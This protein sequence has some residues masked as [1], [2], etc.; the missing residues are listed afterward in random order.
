MPLVAVVGRPNVGKSTFFNRLTESRDSIVDDQPG[1][2]RDRVYGR[3]EW[4]GRGFSIVDTGGLVPDSEDRFEAAI[5]EQAAIAIDEADLILFLVDVTTGIT[6]LDQ[7]IALLLRRSEKPVLVVA[8]KADN[9]ERRWQ[10]ADFWQL[11]VGD[12]H[13]VSSINGIGTGDLLD[14]IVDAL[15]PA[16]PPADDTRLRVA[17]IGRPN[18]GKSSL[19]NAW[20]G[21]ERSIV[22]EIS[23]TTRDSIDSVLKYHGREIV[24]VDTAGL[25]KRARIQENVEFYALL[26]TERAIDECDVAV[27]L[28]DATGGLESQDIRVLKKAEELR[29]GL[30]IGINKWDVIEKDTHTVR[31]YEQVVR[32][33]LATLDY[34]P[35]VT[36]SALSKQRIQKLLETTLAV[37]DNLHR[38]VTTS[39]L[40]DTILPAIEA[41]KPP[42]Y[43]GALVKIKYATQTRTAPPV[44]VFF[45]NHPSGLKEPYRRYLERRLRD[46]FDFTGVPLTVSFR[47]K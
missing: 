12:V 39:Q 14:A 10:A 44:F 1:V 37:A 25:R 21:T 29:K 46:A 8:N 45:A 11:A 3:A 7:D 30:V 9:E 47:R 20:L 34:V 17:V 41:H 22:T 31:E 26:R 38:R 6:D 4:R 28:L 40:N 5:R 19:V 32:E 24:L 23:G 2:T 15:P 35:I 18:V 36:L 33:R 13:P 16:P 27:L 42:P 43:R